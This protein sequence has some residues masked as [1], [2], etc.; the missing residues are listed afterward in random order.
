MSRDWHTPT[1]RTRQMTV[2]RYEIESNLV[3][4]IDSIPKGSTFWDIGGCVGNFSVH[5]AIRALNVFS[6]EPEGAT[7]GILQ[8]NLNNSNLKV[9]AFCIA[10]G[11]IKCRTTLFSE[12]FIA[13]GAHNTVARSMNSY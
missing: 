11:N 4:F 13:G 3:S 6:F 12:Q 8:S 2:F 1:N 9:S 10:L 7:F 5:A